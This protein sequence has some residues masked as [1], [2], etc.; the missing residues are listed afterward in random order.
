MKSMDICVKLYETVSIDFDQMKEIAIETI[1]EV[2]DIPKN[3]FIK[4][5]VL[6]VWY[7]THGSGIDEDVR[8]ATEA[9]K[10]ALKVIEKIKERKK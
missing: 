7:N 5:G 1:R 9:D 8:K 4:D 3:A 6:T 2:Y 10:I